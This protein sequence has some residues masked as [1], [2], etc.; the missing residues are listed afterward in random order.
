M[1]NLK[2]ELGLSLCNIALFGRTDQIKG[3][4]LYNKENLDKQ[5]P[6]ECVIANTDMLTLQ[7]VIF[8]GLLHTVTFVLYSGLYFYFHFQSEEIDIVWSFA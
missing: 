1:L 8:L 7:I 3:N 5:Q 2:N 4:G 6:V